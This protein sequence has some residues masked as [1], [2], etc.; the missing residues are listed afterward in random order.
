MPQRPLLVLEGVDI[1]RVSQTGQSRAN[2]INKMTV[3]PLKKKTV[4][5][6]G[7]GANL[8]VNYALRRIEALEPAFA[9]PFDI[10]LFDGFGEV[11]QWIMAGVYRDTDNGHRMLPFR[12]IVTG[13]LNAWEP[14]ETDPAEM[15]DCNWMFAEVTDY[16]ATLDGQ[17]FIYVSLRERATR[18]LGKDIFGDFNAALG[19]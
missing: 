9:S 13:V 12:A 10:S 19:I 5:H 16:Q 18:Y 3:P 8:E 2:I 1:R 7:G 17:E 15:Q 11:D 4:S 14:S 6:D